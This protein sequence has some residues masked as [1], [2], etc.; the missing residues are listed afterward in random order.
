MMEVFMSGELMVKA[1]K[2]FHIKFY[3]KCWEGRNT[4]VT[5]IIVMQYLTVPGN[6]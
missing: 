5:K 3:D 6:Y 1:V 2:Y 4:L